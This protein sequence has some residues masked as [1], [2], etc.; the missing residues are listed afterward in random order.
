MKVFLLFFLFLS[1]NSI[2]VI[3]Y[4]MINH[5]LGQVIDIF[6]VK[7]NRNKGITAEYE[8]MEEEDYVDYHVSSKGKQNYNITNEEFG[9]PP[10]KA[11]FKLFNNIKFPNET[12]WVNNHLCDIPYWHLIVDGKDYFSNVGTEYFDKF[13]KIVNLNDIKEYC[14]D[15]Y[16][17]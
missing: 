13:K 1:L 3:E 4:K 14:K 16:K 11:L 9:L 12:N 17:K 7:F 15:N 6:S 8:E 5:F 2:E 10:M